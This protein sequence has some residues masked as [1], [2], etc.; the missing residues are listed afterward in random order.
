MN[1]GFLTASRPHFRLEIGSIVTLA[2]IVLK[3]EQVCD[4]DPI[5]SMREE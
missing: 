5:G 2:G 4:S 3:A 1:E